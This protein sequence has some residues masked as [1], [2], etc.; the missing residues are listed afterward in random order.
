MGIEA[1]DGA[2]GFDVRQGGAQR[3]LVEQNDARAALKLVCRETR[4]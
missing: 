4:K 1:L 2:E 3:V